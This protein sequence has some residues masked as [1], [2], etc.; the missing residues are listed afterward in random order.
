[1]VD[2]SMSELSLMCFK[3]SSTYTLVD[4]LGAR[5][6]KQCREINTYSAIC[7]AYVY[8]PEHTVNLWLLPPPC[9]NLQCC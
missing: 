6:T 3:F 5:L 4:I 9:F 2:V 7:S 8:L 1:M